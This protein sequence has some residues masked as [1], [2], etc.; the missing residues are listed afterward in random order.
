MNDNTNE[1]KKNVIPKKQIVSRITG[2]NKPTGTPKKYLNPKKKKQ[3]KTRTPEERKAYWE[4]VK[5]IQAERKAKKKAQRDLEKALGIVK[6]KK[7]N[8]MKYNIDPIKNQK[9]GDDTEFLGMNFHDRAL[10]ELRLFEEAC[11]KAYQRF[12]IN[13]K[14]KNAELDYHQEVK[15]YRKVFNHNIQEITKQEK[16]RLITELNGKVLIHQTN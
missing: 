10:E 13:N 3:K 16:F 1:E 12:Y 11:D 9:P 14:N 5:T 8:I 4:K 7:E 6:I 2:R 15:K